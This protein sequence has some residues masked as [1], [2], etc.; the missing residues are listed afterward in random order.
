M[1]IA[2]LQELLATYPQDLPVMVDGYEGGY[3]DAAAERIAT[4]E[5]RLEVNPEWYYGRHDGPEIESVEFRDANYDG[6][7]I[8][9]LVI[10]RDRSMTDRS[11]KQAPPT[12]YVN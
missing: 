10:S 3:D 4:K 5:V 7:V 11:L 9:A 6:P 8:T 2:E 12:T 1:T